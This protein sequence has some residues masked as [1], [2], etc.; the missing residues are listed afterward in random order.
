[1]YYDLL[2]L[3]LALSD[4]I[5]T[6]LNTGVG[7]F[8]LLLLLALYLAPAITAFLRYHR[9]RASILVIN[10]FLGWTFIGWVV[11][12][13]MSVTNN[14]E[15]RPAVAT[16]KTELRRDRNAYEGYEGVEDL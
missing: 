14:V 11:A 2:M 6:L 13:A 1:M 5:D 16:K 10:L 9:N 3:Y 4:L 12:L 15:D 8:I 7:Q